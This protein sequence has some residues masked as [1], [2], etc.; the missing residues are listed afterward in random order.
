MGGAETEVSAQTHDILIEAADFDP[1]TVR[2]AARRVGLHSPSSYRFERG[3]DPDGIDWA[4]R[5]CCQLILQVAGG[6]LAAGSVDVVSG[7]S[8]KRPAIVLRL[9][10]LPRVLGISIPSDVVQRILVALGNQ[11]IDANENQIE[12]VPPSWRRDLTR[13]IDLIEEVVR[14]HGYDQVPE[15]ARVAMIASHR[16]EWDRLNGRVRDGLTAMGFDEALTVSVVSQD[17]SEAFSPWT[18]HEP[19]RCNTPLLRGADTLRRSLI[20]SLLGARQVNQALSNPH[21]QLFEIARIYLPG[22]DVEALPDERRML[23]LTADGDFF[24]VKG[25][26]ENLALQLDRGAE[27]QVGGAVQAPLLDAV[28]SCELIW[29]G[30]RCGVLGEV[31]AAGKKQFGLRGDVTVAEIQLDGFLKAAGAIPQYEAAILFPAV[32]QD[33]NLIADESV[34]WGDLVGTVRNAGGNGLR[35]IHFR[36]TYRDP[37]KDGTG[38]KRLIFSFTLQSSERTLTRQEADAIRDRIVADCQRAHGTQLLS[39]G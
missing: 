33:L 9:P 27:W 20:P 37:A 15:D 31:S 32:V 36:E 26:L 4:S 7:K 28:R 22:S 8:S 6:E 38:K 3:V 24:H 11:L 29:R 30:E 5:R 39:S 17:W 18:P 1:L 25:V 13:E 2:G 10:Q 16:D 34:L 12:V 14:V 21:I 19:L 23:G 35:N